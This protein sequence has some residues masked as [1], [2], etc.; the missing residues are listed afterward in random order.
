MSRSPY[1]LENQE[2]AQLPSD[3]DV[4]SYRERGWYL[5]EKLFTDAEVDALR[6]AS[7]LFYAGQRDESL[8]SHPPTLAYWT[9]DQ[10]EGLRHNDYIHY[11][12][13]AIRDIIT[14]PLIGAVAARLAEATSIR[15][16]QATLIYKPPGANKETS[17]VPWHF[18]RYYWSTA[19][20][21]KLL[22]AF[23]PFHNCFEE[24]GTI[25]MVDSSHRW[26]EISRDDS[27]TRHFFERDRRELEK[28]LQ[29]NAEYNGCEVHKT[30]MI[31]P[32]GHVSFHHCRIYH[33]S[34]PN[35]ADQ[36]RLAISLHL[37]DGDNRWRPYRLSDGSLLKYNHDYLVRRT[38]TG[39]PDYADPRFCPTIWQAETND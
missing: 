23:I 24:M 8:P 39:E 18:D 6:N 3:E 36:P 10:G 19:T 13:K 35:H 15:V 22:T 9:P 7:E 5:S 1:T 17:I 31:I 26:Q 12:V 37:Q 21:D 28:L 30:P 27:F 38:E 14:K 33:G 25:T 11:E 16:F 29:Q 34:G 4:Q 2:T 20:S 32:K